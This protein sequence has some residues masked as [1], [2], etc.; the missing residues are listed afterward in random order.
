L[1]CWTSVA[2]LTGPLIL[3]AFSTPSTP[4]DAAPSVARVSGAI[5]KHVVIIG[6]GFG[7]LTVARALASVKDVRVTLVDRENHHLFQ[8][9]LY[10]VA[11]AGLSPG[12][13]SIP[14]RAVV[15]FHPRTRVLM[16]EVMDVDHVAK[17]VVL[18]SGDEIDFDYLVVAAGAKTSWFGNDQWADHAVG[19]K[20][21]R[22]A[23]T[24]REQILM[25]FEEAEREPDEARRQELLT[26]VSI[27]GGPTG[28]ETAGAMSELSR[29]TLKRD[30]RVVDPQS[31][32][33]IL[34]E[35]ADRVLTPFDEHLSRSAKE[36]LEELK[37]EVWT[38]R[39]VTDIGEGYVEVDGE[40]VAA[41]VV[42]WASGVTPVSLTE[43]LGAPLE[44]GRVKV[45]ADCSLPDH[46][47]VFAIGDMTYFVDE[48]T[49]EPL[50]GVAQVAIQMGRHVAEIIRYRTQ[51]G[52]RPKFRYRDKGIMATIGRSRA[53][54]QSGDLKLTGYFA[55]LAWL[56]IHIVFLIG[57]RNRLTVLLNWWW[58][59]ITFRRGSRLIAR[60]TMPPG[61]ALEA[62]LS[63]QHGEGRAG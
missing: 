5:E 29:E 18:G 38:G 42:C 58:N 35:M 25:A 20:S 27:G 4:P 60:T 59:Y 12:D 2:R 26:F 19:L 11:T 32:R 56:F 3:S 46:P 14:I 9:L 44:R 40:R 21:L 8:P 37:V 52:H 49:G 45:E 33:V 30:F 57:F 34:V 50:P 7:G 6:G 36:A 16:G 31:I 28:V 23:L 63:E 55:W 22:D 62:E 47:N 54:V 10:Q 17:K 51:A 48:K 41:S 43:K 1:I 39:R 15:R 13:I 61:R 24:L 53:I